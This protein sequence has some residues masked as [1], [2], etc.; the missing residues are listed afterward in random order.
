MVS[1]SQLTCITKSFSDSTD[2]VSKSLSQAANY[3]EEAF[4]SEEH[5]LH[6]LGSDAKHDL[7][8]L[9]RS[10]NQ[11][12]RLCDVISDKISSSNTLHLCYLR[13]LPSPPTACDYGE[14]VSASGIE[15]E[16]R[17]IE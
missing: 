8:G 16:R 1:V 3:Q 15:L 5:G 11:C 14:E 7:Q 2:C 17:N 9:L 12:R 6:M 4:V 13:P 10:T